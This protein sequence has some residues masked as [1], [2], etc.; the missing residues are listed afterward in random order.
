MR[1]NSSSTRELKP[2]RYAIKS[3]S[4][5]SENNNY[6]RQRSRLDARMQE[7]RLSEDDEEPELQ[8]DV[9]SS[10]ASASAT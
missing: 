8:A 9:A 6:L 2:S 4:P 5:I 3:V 1:A 7:F 10:D